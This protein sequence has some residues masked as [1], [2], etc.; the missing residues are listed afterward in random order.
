MKQKLRNKW[1][2]SNDF[3]VLA[4]IV[5]LACLA[6]FIGLIEVS[7]AQTVQVIE[8][9]FDAKIVH[10]EVTGLYYIQCVDS[11]EQWHNTGDIAELYQGFL[12]ECEAI[13]FYKKKLTDTYGFAYVPLNCLFSWNN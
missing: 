4:I 8:S 2:L 3:I 11:C 6:I 10:S 12:L 13:N 1:Y 9:R 7:E 5:F